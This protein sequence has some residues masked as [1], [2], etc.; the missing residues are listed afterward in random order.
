MS[1]I[2]RRSLL[3]ASNT[4]EVSQIIT[5]KESGTYTVPNGTI[6]IDVFM[7]GAGGGGGLPVAPTSNYTA[8]HKGKGGSAVYYENIP[9]TKGEEISVTIGLAGK[10]A[11][12][13]NT[14]GTDGGDTS[15]GDYTA[16]G[17]K[18]GAKGTN[19]STSAGNDGSMACPFGAIDSESIT[20][21]ALFGAD[22]GD[23]STTTTALAGGATGGGK[24]ANRSTDAS[25]ATFYGAGGGGGTIY[26]SWVSTT[27]RKTGDGH[28]GIVILRVTRKLK[29]SDMP[30]VA[31]FAIITDTTQTT[32]TVPANAKKID[33]F[34]VG[35]GGSGGVNNNL[36]A[37]G[38]GHYTGPGYVGNIIY[39]ENIPFSKG[40][41]FTIKVGEGGNKVSGTYKDGNAGKSTIF[42]LYTATGGLGGEYGG[43][44][45][46]PDAEG[47]VCPFGKVSDELTAD[48]KYAA[49]GGY[50]RY[51]IA[52]SNEID[53]SY[54]YKGGGKSAGDD[55]TFYGSSGAASAT[56]DSSNTLTSGSGY[57]GIIIIRYWVPEF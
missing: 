32:W 43:F 23:G 40:E 36:V 17:G 38:A 15:F 2:R 3:Y 52:G 47:T 24:G 30:L 31:K 34:L 54:G 14:A 11:T 46:P 16:A 12:T 21:T 1:T 49:S 10:G 4:I 5:I 8:G 50:Y 41:V 20:D 7:V 22:G 29:E 53:Y 33:I 48:L 37:E 51:N 39:K 25:S 26:K 42:G 55:A 19:T 9:F 6:R 56:A 18:G 35:G 27:I 44:G 13:A 28:D 57:Q 45:Y